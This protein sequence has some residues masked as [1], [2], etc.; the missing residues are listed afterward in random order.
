MEMHK[1]GFA[2]KLH[3]DVVDKERHDSIII[4]LQ[5][6]QRSRSINFA[7]SYG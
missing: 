2:L 6:M 3:E 1:G 7:A 4:Q 5:K